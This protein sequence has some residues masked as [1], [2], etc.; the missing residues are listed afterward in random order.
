MLLWLPNI[1]GDDEIRELREAAAKGEFVD[2][3][4]SAPGLAAAAIKRNEQ[5]APQS[6]LHKRITQVVM[7]ALNRSETFR[8]AALPKII[9][10]PIL[11]RYRAGMGYGTHIDNPIRRWPVPMR[12]DLSITLFLVA[13][14][15]YGGGELVLETPYG[16]KSVK[17]P[18]GHGILYPTTMLHRVETVSAGERLVAVTW[19]QS[20]VQDQ[21]KRSLLWELA[22]VTQ[23][24]Q[25]T[26]PNSKPYHQVSNARANLV[27][28]WATD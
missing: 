15:S 20:M 13:P 24:A 27:R 8:T 28:M 19:I 3:G 23:W 5:L 16:E 26:A 25:D 9:Q 10:P 6:P 14:E 21:G 17:L 11:S 12:L 2:G 18:A 4:Q 7:G 22:Q 1:L